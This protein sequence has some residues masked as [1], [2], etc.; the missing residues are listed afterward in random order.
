MTKTFFSYI[1]KLRVENSYRSG[2][3]SMR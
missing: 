1:P 2:E 3:I